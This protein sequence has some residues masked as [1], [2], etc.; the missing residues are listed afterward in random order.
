MLMA[1]QDPTGQY[2]MQVQQ[3]EIKDFRCFHPSYFLL[4]YAIFF[5]TLCIILLLSA[6][7]DLHPAI[8]TC[9]LSKQMK[10]LRDKHATALEAAPLTW[11]IAL[12]HLK[13]M[14]GHTYPCVQEKNGEVVM[15]YMS[16]LPCSST[17]M[18]W[19]CFLVR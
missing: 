5:I 10:N 18:K 6:T 3:K 1:V 11:V 12:S 14:A 2:K 17:S 7:G 9:T 13:G 8:V 15:V 19:R 16:S 4:G